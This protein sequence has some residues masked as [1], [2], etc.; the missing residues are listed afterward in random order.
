MKRWINYGIVTLVCIICI[1]ST[2]KFIKGNQGY[3]E[4]SKNTPAP[5]DTVSIE[6]SIETT[7]SDNETLTKDQ[8]WEK[9]ANSYIDGE[10]INEASDTVIQDAWTYHINS[11]EVTKEYGEN[12]DA[13]PDYSWY[14]YDENFNLTNGF[15]YL[16][17]GVT[18]QYKDSSA[19]V[20]DLWLNTMWLNIFNSNGDKVGTGYAEMATAS[21]GK[22]KVQSYFH[23]PMEEGE[24]LTADIVYIVAD[25]ILENS[26]LYYVLYINNQGIN[27]VNPDDMGL[28]KIP[29]GVEK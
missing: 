2:M 1:I 27:T 19:K 14:Q 11:V 17:L 4:I 28:I 16:A 6:D 9:I 29:L 10:T 15:S 5:T 8:V 7:N 13:V 21:L 23:N 12:W 24:T 25:E 18:I 3:E 26:E 22:P 20:N